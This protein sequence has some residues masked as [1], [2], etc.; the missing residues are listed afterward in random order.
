MRVD[1]SSWSAG[2]LSRQSSKVFK[3]QLEAVEE[4]STC[5][6]VTLFQGL[7]SQTIPTFGAV[8]CLGS[9]VGNVKITALDS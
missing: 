5:L 2:K 3:N 9:F 8:D 4:E 1:Q 7:L 6:M